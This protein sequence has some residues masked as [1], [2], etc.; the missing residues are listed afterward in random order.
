MPESKINE[1]VVARFKDLNTNSK[2]ENKEAN[3]STS[4]R[5]L[6][7]Q[8]GLFQSIVWRILA[9]IKPVLSAEDRIAQISVAVGKIRDMPAIFQ[10]VRNSEQRH[11]QASQ[12]TSGRNFELLW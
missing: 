12:T 3:S 9:H 1:P 5:A 6:A 11:F 7:Q 8:V 4:N 2:L 10:N